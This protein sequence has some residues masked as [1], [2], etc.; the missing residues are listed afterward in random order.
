MAWREF[1]GLGEM[2]GDG[3]Q[4]PIMDQGVPTIL[5]DG[6]RVEVRNGLAILT[7]YEDVREVG[8]RAIAKYASQPGPALDLGTQINRIRRRLSG[9]GH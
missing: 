5:A 3:D 8:L 2:A 9:R 1:E 7:V 4:T 6:F